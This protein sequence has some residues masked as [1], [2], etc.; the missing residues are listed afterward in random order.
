MMAFGRMWRRA[1]PLAVDGGIRDRPGYRSVGPR[2]GSYVFFCRATALLWGLNLLAGMAMAE[3]SIRVDDSVLPVGGQTAIQL[4][5]DPDAGPVA[6]VGT[7]VLYDPA[8]LAITY[9]GMEPRSFGGV[10]RAVHLAH[11]TP[12][13]IVIGA[14]QVG[15]GAYTATVPE[16]F[17]M[18]VV[19]R[20]TPAATALILDE[21]FLQLEGSN[22]FRELT[23]SD[24]V[25]GVVSEDSDGDSINDAW[26][27]DHFPDL[28]TASGSSDYDGDGV[29]DHDEAL[30]GTDPTIP[31]L[32]HLPI[33][34]GVAQASS[35]RLSLSFLSET[36]VRY[37]VQ[38][39]V[40]LSPP[41]WLSTRFAIT[42]GGN[43]THDVLTGGGGMA[44]IE[45][46]L[47]GNGL[48]FLRIFM[49]SERADP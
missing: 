40:S 43:A 18:L 42:R 24:I 32:S 20:L 22:T 4:Y 5:L 11:H 47:N 35:Y 28:A 17:A 9:A 27:L 37:R 39:S 29:S 41:A 33:I 1:G 12:G 25:F 19:K 2:A 16:A 31:Y 46:P 10:G 36:N 15:G 23:L 26:E 48:V 30:A 21:P 14:A 6:G 8:S 49:A 7:R 13:R 44:E 3:F 38:T 34:E 45:V